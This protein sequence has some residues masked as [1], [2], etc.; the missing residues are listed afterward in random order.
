MAYLNSLS[1]YTVNCEQNGT[2]GRWGDAS[3]GRRI[4]P[5]VFLF[6]Y[7]RYW[8]KFGNL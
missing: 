7:G 4:M 2:T 5:G 8:D 3:T 1:V 6:L